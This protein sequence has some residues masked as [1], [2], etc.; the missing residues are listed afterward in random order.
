V[1]EQPAVV[2]DQDLVHR[3]ARP[4]RARGWRRRRSGP[5][6][7]GRATSRVASGCRRGRGRWWAR[8]GLGMFRQLQPIPPT[9]AVANRRSRRLGSTQ[10]SVHPRSSWPPGSAAHASQCR[11]RGSAPANAGGR[12]ELQRQ[13]HESHCLSGGETVS[14][15]ASPTRQIRPSRDTLVEVN[16]LQVDR[17]SRQGTGYGAEGHRVESCRSGR[18]SQHPSAGS[19]EPFLL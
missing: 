2:E 1:R 14:R 18:E 15:T 19:E 10:H 5:R 13:V 9:R 12:E 11:A 6:R 7:P 17:T 3:S 4:P 8:R 16:L